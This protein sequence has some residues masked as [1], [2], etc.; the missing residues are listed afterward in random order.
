MST[1]RSTRSVSSRAVGDDGGTGLIAT[2]AGVT[3]FLAMLLLAVQVTYDLYAKSAVTAAAFDAVRVVAGADAANDAAARTA[4]EAD[5][6]RA[7]GAYGDR[8]SFEW[9]VADDTVLLH[10]HADNPG[11]LPAAWRRP[12]GIDAIDRTL[13]ARI[14]RLQQ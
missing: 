4:A 10:V 1:I 3:A 9:T 6:R 7:L 11:F 5:A 8:V 12:L 14:E 2:L 13:R